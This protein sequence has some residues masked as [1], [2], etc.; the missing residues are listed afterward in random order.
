MSYFN[1]NCSLYSN[2]IFKIFLNKI[3]KNG[4]KSALTCHGFLDEY[5]I[6]QS[7]SK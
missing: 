7:L 1:N 6:S 3:E 5:G 4:E 2:I